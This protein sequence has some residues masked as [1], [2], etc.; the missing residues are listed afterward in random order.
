MVKGEL[1]FI[2]NVQFVTDFL[3][4]YHSTFSKIY[5]RL[6]SDRLKTRTVEQEFLSLFYML[7]HVHNFVCR[8][9]I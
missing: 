1:S 9:C 3:V 5:I 6:Q 8:T 2:A 4:P 7:N